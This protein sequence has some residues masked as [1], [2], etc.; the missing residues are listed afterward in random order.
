MCLKCIG[1]GTWA[2]GLLW[3]GEG[4]LLLAPSTLVA[5]WR[6][7]CRFLAGACLTSCRHVWRLPYGVAWCL[8]AC[9]SGWWFL[10]Q[11]APAVLQHLVLLCACFHCLL[12]VSLCI[13]A[14]MCTLEGSHNRV[15][16][17]HALQLVCTSCV[18]VATIGVE[19]GTDPA[20]VCLLRPASLV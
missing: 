14:H 2:V 4:F 16:A 1:M 5:F 11:V 9:I 13:W 10:M 12:F 3:H 19:Q 20:V 7:M 6:V 18:R 17:M 8:Y 15:Q